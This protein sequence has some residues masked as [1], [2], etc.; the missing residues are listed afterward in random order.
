MNFIRFLGT[1]LA[2]LAKTLAYG[3]VF[4]LR[5]IVKRFIEAIKKICAFLKLPHPEREDIGKDCTVVNNPSF[6]RPDPCI[7]SQDYLLK[8]GLAVTWDNPDI[9]LRKNGVIVPEDAVE[10]DTDY[11]IEATV[12]N[13][14][15]EAPAVGVSV[16]FSFLTFGVATVESMIG[17]TLVN[18]GVKGGVNHPA[19]AKMPW[20][21]PSTPGHY[22][23]KVVLGWIDDSNPANNV[24][25]NNLNVVA[26]QSPAEFAFRLRNHTTKANQY[27]FEVDDYAIPGVPECKPKIEPEDR[28]TF[29][30]RLRKIKATHARSNFPV[31]ADWI[32][33]LSPAQP[34]LQPD[35]E[36]DVNARIT[37]PAGF[38]GTKPFNVNALYGDTY[39]GG[40]TLVV[41]AV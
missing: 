8:L 14:S 9:V 26:P 40:V 24:G 2:H 16:A 3:W 10:P 18:L 11:E 32:V 22:C 35:E 12:W 4:D 1:V 19:L 6:H 37:P 38:T 5:D 20:R 7:Y 33:E 25:Q 21:T 15:F 36:I 39:A 30:Q 17:G 28:G 27:R 34:T 29:S 41:S 31:P 13:N 23:L